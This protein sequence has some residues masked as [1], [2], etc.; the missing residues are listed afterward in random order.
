M[1]KTLKQVLSMLLILSMVLVLFVGCTEEKEKVVKADYTYKSYS[2]S[3]GNNWNPHTWETN[4]DDSIL[5]YLSL[6]FCTMSIDDSA[7]GIYQWIYQMAT[8]IED[9]T[10]ANQADLTKYA[11]TLPEGMTA[12]EVEGGY[13]YEIK[14]N[15]KAKWE[16]GT[17]IN[18]DS[19]IYSMK[20]LLAPEMKNYR[21]NL[22]YSGESAVAGGYEYYYAGS[23][24]WN[25][26]VLTNGYA[27]SDLVK[28]AD[29]LYT[30]PDG[31]PMK[32]ALDTALDWLNGNALSTYVNA[33]G[34]AY[35]GMDG[36]NALRALADEEGMVDLNDETLA[37]LV[38]V[39]TA[40]A[41]W[42]E[43]DAEAMN[44]LVEGEEMP[45]VGY[46]ETV[47]CYK[48][49][50]YTIRY[51]CQTKIDRNYF[52]TSCT[53]TW[54]VHEGLYEANKETVADLTS[55]KYNTSKET[56]MSYGPYKIESL[57]EGKQ[58]IFT[59]NENWWGWEKD[60]AGNLVSYTDFL[61]D[62]EKQ[63]QYQTTRIVIDVM[64]EAAA[65]QAFMKGELSSWAPS[66][67]DLLTY[68]T[69]EV[70]Y[71]VDETYTMS[72]FFNTD[73]EAL[74]AMDEAKGNTNSVVLSNTNFRKAFS[75]GIDRAEWVTA[76]EGYKPAYALMNNLYHYDVY[77]DPTSSYRS[78]DAAMQAICNLYGVAYGEGTPYATLRDAYLSIN[79]YNLTEAQA[80]MKTACDE[81]VAEGLYKAGD[82]I[83]IRIGYKKGALENADNQQVELMNKYINAAAEGSGFGTI[84]LEP[85]G[86]IDDR[87][88]AVPAG[89]YAIGYGAWGGAAFY[90]FRNLQVYCDT[91]QYSINEAAC[92]DPSTETLTINV[93]GED[94]TMT[95]YEWSGALIGT[96]R[97]NEADFETKLKVTA[98]M[99]EEFLKKYYRIPLA[100]SCV[101]E[102]LSYQ[103]QYYTEDYNIMYGFG[104]IQLL[105]YNY[106][107]AQWAEYVQSQGGTLSYE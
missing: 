10:A 45:V 33:Y 14:L 96:G 4:A 82:A 79:G 38:N 83:H 93:N 15:E 90:P 16:D 41:D 51:V 13:V 50:D 91:E 56:T 21:A 12:E 64:D 23:M 81:L 87:Y 20:Q 5:S 27:I 86:N 100:G 49:D 98:T 92:W 46:D 55:S 17:P 1:R 31:A 62:G 94:V 60:E 37:H 22:Y 32:I 84:T 85:I 11:V 99:E 101:C 48:V 58:L 72:F 76:T 69:S 70:L 77:N 57:Q 67:D 44:Y 80:L 36:Y 63:Q 78:S 89:E 29:G 73:V 52:L 47:G 105:K 107:D 54:L 97:F 95:W 3:L 18:A 30:A 7:N 34:D 75:L 42:G 61:V 104:G 59:Q 40:V 9:V 65:K 2:T 102:M 35:F 19:Y 71:K 43:T 103:C 28:G 88:G 68:A 53:S 24:A 25:D 26:N 8:S 66:A 39:I 106:S 6:P 74:K